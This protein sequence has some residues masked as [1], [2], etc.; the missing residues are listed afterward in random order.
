MGMKRIGLINDDLLVCYEL[1]KQRAVWGF[2]AKKYY[3]PAD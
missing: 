3:T 2:V 1:R